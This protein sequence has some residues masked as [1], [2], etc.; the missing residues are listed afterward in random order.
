MQDKPHMQKEL[1][2]YL[3]TPSGKNEFRSR[4]VIAG[5]KAANEIHK[6]FPGMYLEVPEVKLLIDQFRRELVRVLGRDKNVCIIEFNGETQRVPANLLHD[7]VPFIGERIGETF[8]GIQGKLLVLYT[9]IILHHL[10]HPKTTIE[11]ALNRVK[12]LH[13]LPR[14][15]TRNPPTTMNTLRSY[16][17]Q[18]KTREFRHNHILRVIGVNQQR[19]QA[20]GTSGKFSVV[21]GII[22][23]DV[24]PIKGDGNCLFRSIAKSENPG[25][26]DLELNAVI[27]EYRRAVTDHICQN[28]FLGGNE[29]DAYC[30][31]EKMMRDGEWG[32][33]REVAALAD[34]LKRPIGVYIQKYPR[35]FMTGKS[36]V[37]GDSVYKI[38]I[39]LRYDGTHYELLKKTG[40][41]KTRYVGEDPEFTPE[42]RKI[43]NDF[44]ARIS[45]L[46]KIH[47]NAA[48][49]AAAVANARTNATVAPVRAMGAAVANAPRPIKAANAPVR[50]MGA[51]ASAAE[52]AAANAPVRAEEAAEIM[53]NA[54][55]E[56]ANAPKR[57]W[58]GWVSD[59][60]GE[61]A[62]IVGGALVGVG[63]FICTAIMVFR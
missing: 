60:D 22:E 6:R 11:T 25:F 10:S 27:R 63:S 30:E 28:G 24:I 29:R 51:E 46:A 26:N 58:F 32:G 43:Y 59:V 5:I 48:R 35:I 44:Y 7:P 37:Y 2:E 33:E 40:T 16:I 62:V 19:Q 13:E 50:A 61:D 55:L 8:P 12:K 56:A 57:D 38:P 42:E 9:E 31:Q 23:A 34:I 14:R 53:A 36:Y 21:D 49:K 1:V 18:M 17:A 47:D 52:N 45:G 15:G 4:A 20:A 39:H 3:R 41:V 54:R